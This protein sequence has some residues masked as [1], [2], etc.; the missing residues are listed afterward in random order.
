MR[1]L[2][3]LEVLELLLVG[4]VPLGLR[5]LTLERTDVPLDLGDDVA[6]A[7]QVLLRELHLPL[8]L[9]LLRLELGDAGGLLDEHPPVFRL[10]RHD[11]PDL[12]L[13]DD[14]VRLRP[15][16]GAE[17]EV[18]DVLQTDL[19]LVDQ[20]LAVAGAMQPPRDGDLGV[21]L[22]FDGEV[23]AVLGL[24][25]Q[26]DLGEV[27]PLPRLG[28]AEE[29]VLHAA[30]A[31][32]LGRLLAHAPADGVDDVRLAAPVGAD[33]AEDLV[34]EVH[35]GPVDERLETGHLELLDFHRD[36]RSETRSLHQEEAPEGA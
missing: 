21:V 7:Q 17:E 33:D 15:R 25:G 18:G 30:A 36:S 34:V 20:V 31:E 11:E 12:P 19:R 3:E 32:V 29:D 2:V 26:R 35:D 4:D 24:E 9:L 13:L 14:R 28:A 27:G 16:A 23:L 1:R 22:V 10:G 8:G 5:R 6:H